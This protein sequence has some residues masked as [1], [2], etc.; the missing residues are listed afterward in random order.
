MSAFRGNA[1]VSKGL[2]VREVLAI[3]GRGRSPR[4]YGDDSASFFTNTSSMKSF[5]ILSLNS[6]GISSQESIQRRTTDLE[7]LL[8]AEKPH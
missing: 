2:K 6:A 1:D 8:D 4:A 7:N 3:T 5:S